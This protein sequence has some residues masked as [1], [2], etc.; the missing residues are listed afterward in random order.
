MFYALSSR[1]G[2]NVRI[3]EM[4]PPDR[5]NQMS[6]APS[7]ESVRMFQAASGADVRTAASRLIA[8]AKKTIHSRLEKSRTSRPRIG[9]SDNR[10]HP[11]KSRLSPG[12]VQNVQQRHERYRAAFHRRRRMDRHRRRPR[13]LRTE[14]GWPN[15]AVRHS[16]RCPVLGA[17][18]WVLQLP[19]AM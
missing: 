17:S 18:V 6:A 15:R 7:R 14:L 5:V 12:R 10:P 4:D 16:R 8:R 1:S 13:A 19:E 2:G 3:P 9:L 11:G